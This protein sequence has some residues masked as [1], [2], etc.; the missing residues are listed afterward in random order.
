MPTQ[1]KC[2]HCRSADT[3]VSDRNY[4]LKTMTIYLVLGAVGN[5]LWY[6]GLFHVVALIGT[7]FSGAVATGCLLAHLKG[8]DNRAVCSHCN[9]YFSPAQDEL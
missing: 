1:V 3:I 6:T 7:L 4:H 9:H 5:L 2:P 8:D